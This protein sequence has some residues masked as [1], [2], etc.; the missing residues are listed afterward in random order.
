MSGIFIFLDAQLKVETAMGTKSSKLVINVICRFLYKIYVMRVDIKYKMATIAGYFNIALYGKKYVVFLI[1]QS[2]LLIILYIN[3]Q[4]NYKHIN[5]NHVNIR[6]FVSLEFVLFQRCSI[7]WWKYCIVSRKL[8]IVVDVWTN[9]W[10]CLL[11][12][13]LY[14]NYVLSTLFL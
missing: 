12:D 9:N 6:L 13:Y 2:L 14:W 5:Y 3:V 11:C 10:I 4:I 1:P 8:K 7:W